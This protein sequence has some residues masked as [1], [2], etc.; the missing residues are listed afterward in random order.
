MVAFLPDLCAGIIF[1]MNLLS[2]IIDT[3]IIV[4]SIEQIQSHLGISLKG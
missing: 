1:K 2:I 4:T 3:L